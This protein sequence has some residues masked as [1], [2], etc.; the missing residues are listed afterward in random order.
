MKGVGLINHKSY[1]KN[2]KSY[3]KNHKSYIYKD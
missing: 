3:I 1:I 2:H